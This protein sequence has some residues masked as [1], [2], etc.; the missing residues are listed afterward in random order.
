MPMPNVLPVATGQALSSDECR[1]L[2]CLVGIVIPA[3]AEYDVPGADDEAIFADILSS[4]GEDLHL[5]RQALR[6][7]DGL[8][9]GPFADVP[10]AGQRALAQRLRDEHPASAKLLAEITVKSYYRDDRVMRSLG[11]EPRPPFP[12]GFE[13]EPGDWSL[14][15]PVRARGRIYR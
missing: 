7:L 10:V 2:R 12:Q 1:S 6:D 15:A 9:G 3:S 5:V 13:L 11:M 8:S 4:V 14:L